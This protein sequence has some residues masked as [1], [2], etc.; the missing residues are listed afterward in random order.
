M[1]NDPLK[2]GDIVDAE[3]YDGRKLFFIAGG[4]VV[5]RK[6]RTAKNYDTGKE[7][8]VWFYT[9]EGEGKCV[10]KLVD[11]ENMMNLYKEPFEDKSDVCKG[12]VI[13]L[14]QSEIKQRKRFSKSLSKLRRRHDTH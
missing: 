7:D 13:R 14:K 1:R 12:Y 3:I 5:E 2:I 10:D 8:L 4:R 11:G 6:Q 9:V